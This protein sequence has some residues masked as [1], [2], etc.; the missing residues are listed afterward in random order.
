MS[1]TKLFLILTAMMGSLPAAGE[2][3]P[4]K[5]D[6]LRMTSSVSVAS[7]ELHLSDDTT[8]TWLENGREIHSDDRLKNTNI[9]E[10]IDT[11]IESTL[12]SLGFEFTAPKDDT[13]YQIAYTAALEKDLTDQDILSRFGLL[14]GYPAIHSNQSRFERGSLIIY[15]VDPQRTVVWRCATQAAVDF[16]AD[17]ESRQKRIARIVKDMLETLPRSR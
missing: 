1:R 17:K 8:F 11:S 15:L 14:P 4:G 6:P 13:R 7:P 3:L 9:K 2:R 16:E 12:V 5:P 10:M